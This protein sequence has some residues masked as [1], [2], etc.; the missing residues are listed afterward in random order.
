MCSKKVHGLFDMPNGRMQRVEKGGYLFHARDKVHLMHRIAEGEVHLVRQTEDGAKMVFQ[1]AGPG[2]ILAE[3][4]LY[5]RA[6]HCDG[7]AIEESV[8]QTL[9]RADFISVLEKDSEF[10]HAW[11]AH[12]AKSVQS[13]R[14][15][16]EIRTLRTVAERLDAWCAE[17]GALP[18]KGHW[19]DVAAELGVSREALY[20]ELA[21][22]R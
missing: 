14:L 12:L 11:A 5:A 1:R 2:D 17:F 18:E 4:S 3:A 9:A 16:S 10:A 21:R 7:Q 22:R 6:Y 20:R 8:V 13:A 19:Q 15:A